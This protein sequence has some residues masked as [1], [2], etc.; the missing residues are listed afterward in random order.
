MK[1]RVN[2]RNENKEPKVFS[3]VNSAK[4]VDLLC[5][6]KFGKAIAY[7]LFYVFGVDSV[8]FE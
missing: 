1:A 7:V 2:F 4:L 6:T 3:F 8:V 5:E